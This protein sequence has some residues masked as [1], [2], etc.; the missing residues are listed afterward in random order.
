MLNG[1]KIIIKD[2]QYMTAQTL[3]VDEWALSKE[4]I[5]IFYSSLHAGIKLRDMSENQY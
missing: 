3:H 1:L 5:T 2:V 4:L